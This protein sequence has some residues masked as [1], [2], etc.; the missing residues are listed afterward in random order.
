MQHDEVQH[1][2]VKLNSATSRGTTS[3]SATLNGSISRSPT[4]NS[5]T[6]IKRRVNSAILK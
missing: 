2:I 1:H 4:S 6:L 3:N 5:R